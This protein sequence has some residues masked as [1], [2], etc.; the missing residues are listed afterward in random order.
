[1]ALYLG[2]SKRHS[3]FLV[4]EWSRPNMNT[5]ECTG[6]WI[7]I[8]SSVFCNDYHHPFQIKP[9]HEPHRYSSAA[10]PPLWVLSDDLAAI[11]VIEVRPAR[12][13]M[14]W[15]SVQGQAY[16]YIEKLNKPYQ[17]TIGIIA[18]GDKFLC[19]EQTPLG[20][21]RF[22]CTIPRMLFPTRGTPA[23]VVH[24]SE[25]VETYFEAVKERAK[26]GDFSGRIDILDSW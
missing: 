17:P 9:Y 4:K 2:T 10:P 16:R 20:G 15:G 1:M 19:W 12:S 6:I 3:D 7:K 23:S 24:D 8:M 14:N 13:T 11:I 25:S 26:D 22:Q 5:A 21:G 18:H